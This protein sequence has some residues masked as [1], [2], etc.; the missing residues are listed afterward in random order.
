MSKENN[1][2]NSQERLKEK[3]YNDLYGSSV[4]DIH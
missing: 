2:D 1:N 3:A 4:Q